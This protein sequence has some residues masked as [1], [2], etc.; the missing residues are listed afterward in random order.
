MSSFSKSKLFIIKPIPIKQHRP[1]PT[2]SSSLIIQQTPSFLLPSLKA[3]PPQ[4]QYLFS[5]PFPNYTFKSFIGEGGFGACFLVHSHVY[6][7][8]F[9]AKIL[10]NVN[11][12]KA[13]NHP[14]ISHIASID[15]QYVVRAYDY[16]EDDKFLFLILEYCPLGQIKNVL[17]NS[18]NDILLRSFYQMLLGLDAIHKKHIAH[19]DIKPANILADQYGRPKIIDFGISISNVNKTSL[20]SGTKPYQPPEH[21]DSLEHDP[22]KADIWSLGVTFYYL[23]FGFLPWASSD[24]D[25]MKVMIMHAAFKIPSDTYP[26]IAQ[27]IKAMI[28]VDPTSRPSCERLLSCDFFSEFKDKPD[29]PLCYAQPAKLVDQVNNPKANARLTKRNST[30]NIKPYK[31]RK[32]MP[33]SHNYGPNLLLNT[34]IKI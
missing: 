34:P 2:Q 27:L 5:N 33:L 22:Y 9:V 7:E 17:K 11:H 15:N 1:I 10:E 23:A 6:R 25:N 30:K 19:R 26:P 12:S 20:N 8:D 31:T 3:V 29:L 32:G 24:S 14:E 13:M 28:V 16:F 4:F 21:F 18:S